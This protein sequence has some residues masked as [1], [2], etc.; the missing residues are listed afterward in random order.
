MT[1]FNHTITA[2]LVAIFSMISTPVSAEDERELLGVPLSVWKECSKAANALI[3]AA[4]LYEAAGT[5]TETEMVHA[6]YGSIATAC[7]DYGPDSDF[8]KMKADAWS[9]KILRE[10]ADRHAEDAQWHFEQWKRYY[11]EDWKQAQQRQQEG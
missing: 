3:D 4:G 1:N 2:A 5:E 6:A 11:P 7:H 9:A 10:V 8:M